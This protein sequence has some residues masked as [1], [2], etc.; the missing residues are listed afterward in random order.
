[1]VDPPMGTNGTRESQLVLPGF[2][3]AGVTPLGPTTLGPVTPEEA[4]TLVVFV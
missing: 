4:G 1:M 2:C 3:P